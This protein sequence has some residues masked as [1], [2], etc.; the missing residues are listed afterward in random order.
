MTDALGIR[1]RSAAVDPRGRAEAEACPTA[2][3]AQLSGLARPNSLA[4]ACESDD[5]ARNAERSE[6][7]ERD[8]NFQGR[9]NGGTTDAAIVLTPQEC[10]RLA[11]RE[12]YIDFL[13][14]FEF[15]WFATFTFRTDTHPES[16]LKRFYLFASSLNSRLYG[17]NWQRDGKIGVYW[18]NAIER[19][20]RGVIHFH[21]LL[22]APGNLN[23]QARRL[24][25]MDFWFRL[26][27]IARIERVDSNVDVAAYV[28]KY[29]TKGGDI[30]FS[31]SLRTYAK[32]LPLGGPLR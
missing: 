9:L 26:A 22:A 10:N 5:T 15:E 29:L 28:S 23:T 11:V 16:A 24:F 4:G 17:R 8:S 13:T 21:A 30:E 25:W 14:R 12:A 1:A 32:Q 6:A 2:A 20:K 18:V 31:R 27:G 19:Q 3:P 7:S